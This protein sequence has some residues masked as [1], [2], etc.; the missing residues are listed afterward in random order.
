MDEKLLEALKADGWEVLTDPNRT[1]AGDVPAPLVENECCKCTA[2]LM[3]SRKIDSYVCDDCWEIMHHEGEEA[4]AVKLE[5]AAVVKYLRR[6][7]DT[8]ALRD[9]VANHLRVMAAA[10]ETGDHLK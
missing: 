5:R 9:G 3:R 7:A 6:E 1:S 2:K 4:L 10:I 8:I